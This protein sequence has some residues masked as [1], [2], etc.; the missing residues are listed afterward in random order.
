MSDLFSAVDTR[1]VAF[2]LQVA[3]IVLGFL[4]LRIIFDPSRENAP[5]PPRYNELGMVC[6]RCERPVEP[7]AESCPHCGNPIAW[8]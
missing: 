7:G 3:G 6:E 4:G 2:P 8:E 1:T 5:A